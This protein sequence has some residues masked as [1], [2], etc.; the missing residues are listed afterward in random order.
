[1]ATNDFVKSHLAMPKYIE[2]YGAAFP[3]HFDMAQIERTILRNGGYMTLSGGKTHGNGLMFHFKEYWKCLWPEDDQTWWTDLIIKEVLANQFTAIVGPASSWKTSTMSRMVL[4]DWSLFPDCTYVIM[5]STTME[6][7]RARIYGE[8]TNLWRRAKAR[9]PWFPG[10]PIDYKAVIA[11]EDVEIEKARDLRNAIVGVPCFPSGTM[12][13]TPKGSVP[14]ESIKQGDLVISADGPNIV[15]QCSTRIAS[16]LIRV[17]L[18]DGRI[19]DCTEEHPFFT[20]NGWIKARDLMTFDRLLSGHETLSILRGEFGAWLSEPEILF[21]NLPKLSTTQKVRELRSS[22]STTTKTHKRKIP[23]LFLRTPM[24]SAVGREARTGAKENYQAMQ[25]LR[26]NHGESSPQ[27]RL[28]LNQMSESSDTYA[29]RLVREE[30]RFNERRTIEESGA[31]LQ[32]VLQMERNVSAKTQGRKTSNPRRTPSL[33]VVPRIN[34]ESQIRYGDEEEKWSHTLVQVRHRFSGS[35]IGRGDRWRSSPDKKGGRKGHSTHQIPNGTWVDRVEILERGSDKRFDESEGGYRVH[36]LE[37]EGHPSYSVNG[38][39]VHNCKNSS[40]RFVGMSAYAGR[41]N[42]RVW[43]VADEFQFMQISI[44][45]A[46]DNLISNGPNLV[47]GFV[48]DK[49][50]TDHGQPLPGYKCVFI[51]NTN[52]SVPNNPLDVV[53]EPEDGW[54][55]VPEDGKTKCWEG[56]KHPQHPVKCRVIN[57]DG[58]DS[59]NTPYPISKPR[60]PRLSGPHMI[61]NY[62]EGSES[63]FSQARGIFKFGLAVFKIITREVCD[64]FHAF[65]GVTWSGEKPTTKIGMCDAAYG[66]LGGDRCPVGWLEFGKCT[67]GVTRLLFREYWLV[68]IVSNPDMIPEDQIAMYCKTKMEQ[69]GVKPNNFFFDGR[70]SLAMSFA[71]VWSPDV[72]AVEFGGIPTDRPAGADLYTIDPHTK[73]RRIKTAR[74]HYVNF[75]SELWWGW[76][77]AVESDQIRG[78]RF[79]IV[80]DG[81]PREWKKMGGGKIQVETK[82]DMK[83]RTGISPDLADMFVTGLEGARRSGF[84]IRRIGK[85][86]EAE[87]DR[88]NWLDEWQNK[89]ENL[90]RSKE[91]HRV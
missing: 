26:K 31:F 29:L 3:G 53:A 1:M 49:T 66:T 28:L 42:R 24:F 72:H 61:R 6:G 17:H 76:R 18:S 82:R 44:L 22:V 90:L 86:A 68:P 15:Y 57:L 20:S 64:Q 9:C 4:M 84:E 34:L 46:Q 10:N 52:P 69:V 63:Y 21:S 58:A 13:D 19:I 50:R 38:V 12:V 75:V 65:D 88:L 27:P 40:G 48:N 45:Q 62:M 2:K 78:L 56:R 67:D 33:E 16:R 11:S 54:G 43:C 73:F 30:V 36:N 60:Y 87:D 41:K 25:T 70:G 59:P 80:M 89:A 79:D 77:Y 91:L 14:I 51:G 47:P 74:E 35:E 5:S 37:V 71:R 55:S 23:W 85:A 8:T 7:L 83:K 32:H 39:I 81:Q